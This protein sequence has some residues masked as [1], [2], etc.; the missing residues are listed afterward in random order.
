[1]RNGK[2]VINIYIAKRGLFFGEFPI[3]FIFSR[4]IPE[5]LQKENGTARAFRNHFFDANE[6]K[7][8]D[9]NDLPPQ[10]PRKDRGIF[11]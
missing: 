1:M 9:K 6:V 3:V 11:L 2:G 7:M 4:I 10:E 5:I 8:A